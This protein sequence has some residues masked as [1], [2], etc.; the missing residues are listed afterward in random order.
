MEEINLKELFNYL[1]SKLPLLLIITFV[2]LLIGNIY[3]LKF[4]VPMY[5]STTTLVL[6]S[7]SDAN[8]GITQN[9]L[10]LNNNLVDTYTEIIKSKAVLNEVI[11]NLNLDESVNVLSS[12]ITV[13]AVKNTQVIKLK[14]SDKDNKKAQSIADEVAKAFIKETSRIYKLNN[15]VVIDKASLETKPYNMNI[16]KENIIY[17]FGGVMLSLC[18]IFLMYMLDTTI[19]NAHEV[20]EKL[21]LNVLGSV[22]KVGGKNNEKSEE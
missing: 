19:N 12:K 3:S 1:L 20:E 22:P 7:E 4:K 17:V 6:V 14:V 11:N 2:L 9:D 18:I 21:N 13:S 8:I 16:I 15:V 10:T 5:N